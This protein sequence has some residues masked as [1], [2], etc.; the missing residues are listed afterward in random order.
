M[1]EALPRKYPTTI[2]RDGVFFLVKNIA[3]ARAVREFLGIDP[4]GLGLFD[5]LSRRNIQELEQWKD[6]WIKTFV[7][8]GL[9]DWVEF[10]NTQFNAFKTKLEAPPEPKDDFPQIVRREPYTF[11][12]RNKDEFRQLRAL[13]RIFPPSNDLDSF[14]G[15]KDLAGLQQW[16]N[17]WFP[18][19]GALGRNDL[20]TFIDGKFQEFKLKLE[21]EP[22]PEPEKPLGQ[23]II[24]FILNL[25][26][27][28]FG[29]K[30][31]PLKIA[32]EE[33]TGRQLTSVEW[34]VVKLKA[35]N[36]IVPLNAL[37]KLFNDVNL[38]GEA[39]EFG[40]GTDF[41]DLAFALLTFIPG[42]K[43]ASIG[44]KLGTKLGRKG[45]LE[46][47]GQLGLK[48]ASP[49]II[50]SI[51]KSGN[52]KY[53]F[54]GARIDPTG[55]AK[56]APKLSK[57]AQAIISKGLK[58]QHPN[59]AY[60]LWEEA[61]LNSELAKRSFSSKTIDFI[62]KHKAVGVISLLG[63]IWGVL[64]FEAFTNWPLADNIG[65]LEYQSAKAVKTDF[66]A[67]NITKEKALEEM[68]KIIAILEGAL[69][70]IELSSKWNPLMIAFGKGILLTAQENLKLGRRIRTEIEGIE[71]PAPTGHLIITPTPSDSKVSVAGQIPTTG[72]FSKEF[73]VGTYDFTVSKFGFISQSGQAN[74][75]E[76]QTSEINI[77][78]I[79]EVDVVLPPEEVKG[80]L[81]IEAQPEDSII[82]VAGHE[83]ITT[84]GTYE[85]TPGSYGIKATKEGFVDQIKTAFV[86]SDQDT[87]VSFI[88]QEVI[89]PEEPEPPTPP[90]LL[91]QAVITITSTPT[92]ADVYINGEYTF[93]K[94]PYTVVLEK[95]SYIIRVQ[96]DGYFPMEVEAEIEEGEV[97]EIPITLEPIPADAPVQ[98]PFIPFQPTYPRGFEQLYPPVEAPI[99]F[100]DPA[101]PAEIE[102]LVNIE[103]TDAKPW[104]GRIYSIAFQDL[105][106]PNSLPEVLTSDNEEEL[107]I[108]FLD[109]FNQIN[110]DTLVGFKLA[111]DHRY[112]FNKLML[113]RLQ[114]KAWADIELR[115]VKQLLD[116]VKEEFV[117]FPDKTG[118]LDDYGKSLLGKGKYG[119]QENMLKRYLAKDFDYV[120]AFQENQLDVTNG[121]Y[122]LHRFSSSGSSQTPIST[123]NPGTST[124]TTN[125][126]P[127]NVNSSGQKQCVNCL[128]FNPLD[129]TECLV[130]GSTNFR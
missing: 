94:T 96:K 23:K 119:T 46:V 109:I 116:Q 100:S 30:F 64:G 21:P 88:L 24:E 8:I 39:E 38:N 130:C 95:G 108:R 86:R 19:F 122:Q 55:W 110:P 99:L 61:I 85:L 107:L 33:A 111:F 114:S 40:T 47:A 80:K 65:F 121:L 22:E 118:K 41:A 117:Y 120:K 56:L 27:W 112:I 83:E 66:E 62:R 32:Y 115:D 17:I 9:D 1:V 51:L 102:L 3:Q 127:G 97:E 128:A 63:T 50:E 43:L 57:E 15:G 60:R 26:S 84:P 53:I 74:V 2:G 103:T 16:R 129:A 72:I 44:T 25:R 42:A 13:L 36:W 71:P 126:N 18:I 69:A 101:P 45:L 75:I 124:P 92:N 78:L 70:K 104:K 34:E 68:D 81:I 29:I 14:L 91:K 58:K 73:P 79:E 12:A 5:W 123:P 82:T 6:F 35:I 93:T 11:D 7:P 98:L 20:L 90:I 77:N 52:Y 31:D 106:V 105:S 113:H 67:G 59:A 28:P 89:L 125:I 4:E 76:D 49:E 87:K 48:K 37:S 54:E 10:I